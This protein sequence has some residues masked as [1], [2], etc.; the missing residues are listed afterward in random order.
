MR[1]AKVNKG[2]VGFVGKHRLKEEVGEMKHVGEV[3][4]QKTDA[5]TPLPAGD[6]PRRIHTART[7]NHGIAVRYNPEL[8]EAKALATSIKQKL[9]GYKSA[10]TLIAK[11]NA[12]I[13]QLKAIV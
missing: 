12:L 7:L 13:K 5:E 2:I 10:N 11:T 4:S 1:I 9:K 6:I 3:G 8:I